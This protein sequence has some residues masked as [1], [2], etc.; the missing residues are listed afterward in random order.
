[1]RARVWTVLVAMA[2]VLACA[3][4]LGCGDSATPRRT[5]IA[6]P[7]F[8]G[9]VVDAPPGSTCDSAGDC[10]SGNCYC[11]D[12]ASDLAVRACQARVCDPDYACEQFCTTHG[13]PARCPDDAG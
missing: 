7:P 1:M 11:T 6:C 2:S 9:D 10:Q 8:R 13:G 4:A 5:G 12:G 3:V